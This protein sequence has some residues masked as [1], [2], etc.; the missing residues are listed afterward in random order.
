MSEF[1]SGEG[2]AAAG[3]APSRAGGQKR[4]IESISSKG[5]GLWFPVGGGCCRLVVGS[6]AACLVGSHSLIF[7]GITAFAPP[8]LCDL[9]EEILLW[10][11]SLLSGPCRA[12]CTALPG[13]RVLLG[14][15]TT[16]WQSTRVTRNVVSH[17][18]CLEDL[19]NDLSLDDGPHRLTSPHTSAAPLVSRT[20]P[21]CVIK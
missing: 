2:G 18:L 11:R 7:W 4:P 12:D 1:S 6:A 9:F 8:V 10:L 15:K 3:L 17:L 20:S 21:L 19:R 16:C 14:L 5:D 13:H